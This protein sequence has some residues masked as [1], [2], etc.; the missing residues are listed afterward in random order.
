MLPALRNRRL[1]LKHFQKPVKPTA[2]T[3]THESVTLPPRVEAIVDAAEETTCGKEIPPLE[4]WDAAVQCAT[5]RQWRPCTVAEA[6]RF[7]SSNH[8]F[9]CKEAGFVCTQPQKYSKAE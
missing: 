6:P 7:A 4:E 3:A 1:R 9:F 8:G 2:P 5:C